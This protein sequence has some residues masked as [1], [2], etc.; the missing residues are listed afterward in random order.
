MNFSIKF[1][2]ATLGA[3]AAAVV[4]VILRQRRMHNVRHNTEWWKLNAVE[5]ISALKAGRV[6]PRILVEQALA[7]IEM[8]N[9]ATNSIVTLCKRR[10]LDR[11]DQIGCARERGPLQG[12]PIVIKDNQKLAG[13]RCTSSSAKDALSIAQVSDPCIAAVEAAGG[14][15]IGSTNLPER[16]VVRNTW[17][18]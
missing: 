8:S 11:A 15:I 5:V 17:L 3:G 7:R 4:A 9:R 14:I 12:L 2:V 13:V 1:K 10:A 6:T 16:A 18:H